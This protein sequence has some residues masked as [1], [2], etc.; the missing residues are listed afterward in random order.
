MG[1]NAS[2]ATHIPD[3]AENVAE[4]RAHDAGSIT[5]TTTE[6]GVL[7]DQ[8]TATLP[9]QG[10]EPFALMI[11]ASVFAI[12]MTGDNSY[13]LEVWSDTLADGSDDPVTLLRV[14]IKAVSQVRLEVESISI[15]EDHEWIGVRAVLSGSSTPS[16]DYGCNI[17]G[18][19]H[20]ASH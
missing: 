7:I 10:R 14:P 20:H 4:L 17:V 1:V 18:S 6:P 9:A 2:R 19:R 16:I 13:F 11:A 15:P 3:S 12:N 5:A 8:F